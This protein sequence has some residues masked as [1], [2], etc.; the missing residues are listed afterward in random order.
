MAQLIVERATL[1]NYLLPQDDLH[2]ELSQHVLTAVIDM[3]YVYLIKAQLPQMEAAL[4]W[5]SDDF[6]VC[7]N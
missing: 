6:I 1:I 7:D 4:Q 3:F 5:V 2:T